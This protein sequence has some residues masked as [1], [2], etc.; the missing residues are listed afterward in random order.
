M[1]LVIPSILSFLRPP[2]NRSLSP[3]L[4]S[5]PLREKICTTFW[6]KIFT[7]SI[8][9]N[10]LLVPNLKTHTIKPI[11]M[12]KVQ[13]STELLKVRNLICLGFWRSYLNS[14]LVNLDINIHYLHGMTSKETKISLTFGIFSWQHHLFIQ[15][16]FILKKEVL[17]FV[18]LEIS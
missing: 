6:E 17:L 8:G 3:E 4:E 1:G 2:S 13:M 14:N 12:S 7:I 15:F 9:R 18:T 5:S 16:Q 11:F 10:Y